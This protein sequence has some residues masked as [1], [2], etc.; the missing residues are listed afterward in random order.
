MSVDQARNLF[1]ELRDAHTMVLRLGTG[2][3][4]DNARGQTAFALVR[5]ES[6][7][8]ARLRRPTGPRPV[9]SNIPDEISPSSPPTCASP[10]PTKGIESNVAE[11]AIDDGRNRLPSLCSVEA[12]RHRRLRFRR[13]GR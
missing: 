13:V 6:Q 7:S 3:G 5:H 2:H 8:L 11:C 9:H 10:S 12:M 4:D 1:K